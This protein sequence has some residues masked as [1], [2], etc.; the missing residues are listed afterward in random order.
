MAFL[1]KTSPFEYQLLNARSKIT[2]SILEFINILI[3]CSAICTIVKI[4]LQAPGINYVDKK[5]KTTFRNYLE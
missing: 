5:S 3:R 4:K 2:I 1:M